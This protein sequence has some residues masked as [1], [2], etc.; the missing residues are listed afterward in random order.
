M[1]PVKQLKD[2]VTLLDA[3]SV[4]HWVDENAISLDGEPEVTVVNLSHGVDTANIQ[5]ILDNA[6]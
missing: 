3:N 5:N 2:V 4:P 6:S 1:V